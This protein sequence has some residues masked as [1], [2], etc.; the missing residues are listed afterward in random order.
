MTEL[1]Q[2]RRPN[3]AQAEEW[4]HVPDCAVASTLVLVAAGR[5]DLEECVEAD[6]ANDELADLLLEVQETERDLQERY[7][8][9]LRVGK[10]VTVRSEACTI[11][12][13]RVETATQRENRVLRRHGLLPARRPRRAPSVLGRLRLRGPRRRGAGRP[14]HGRARVTR[15]PPDDD[16]EPHRSRCRPGRRRPEAAS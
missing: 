1:C 2:P 11:K 10:R 4:R 9:L 6:P 8:R 5:D 14:G 3:R 7:D 15:G 13:A 16:D 12:H